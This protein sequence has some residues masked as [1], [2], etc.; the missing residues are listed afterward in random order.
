MSDH[1]DTNSDTRQ[2]AT[3]G[4][5]L[6]SSP[7]TPLVV[8]ISGKQGSG[9]TTLSEG[10]CR[11][12]RN[13]QFGVELLKFAGP[14]YHMHDMIRDY[15]RTQLGMTRPDKDGPLLQLLGTEWGRN[16]IA[17][18]VW[19]NALLHRIHISPAD[20]ILID[21]CR[22]PNELEVISE[23]PRKLS[24]RLEASVPTRRERCPAWRDN[25]THPSETGLDNMLDRFDVIIDA[26]KFNSEQVLAIVGLQIRRVEFI[27]GRL[28][29]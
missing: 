3:T 19:I 22:F 21:D 7:I 1:P 23:L 16:T 17:Q 14:I 4:S 25:D 24:V 15:C 27:E 18:D 10:L 2:S 28:T 26:D 9:K 6:D 12:L 13:H 11:E 8:V 29:R 5:N 20:V